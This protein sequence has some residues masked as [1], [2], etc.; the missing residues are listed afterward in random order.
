MAVIEMNWKPSN[1]DLRVF[2]VVQLIAASIV[3]W[4]LH[5][6]LGWDAVAIGAMSISAVGLIAGMASPQLLRPFFV[7]W[8]LAAF[9]VGWVMSHVLVGIVFYGVVT[10]IGLV[11]RATG[12]DALQLTPQP[13]ASTYWSV[14]PK[15]T[16]AARYFRQF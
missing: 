10:P 8:M 6:R 9:P 2:A 14:R 15:Q 16:D 13:G 11:L 4:L 7:A 12:R 3:A 1:R 5:R